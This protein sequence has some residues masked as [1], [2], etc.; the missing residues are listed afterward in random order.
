[1]SAPRRGP[2][3]RGARPGAGPAIEPCARAAARS[4]PGDIRP[5]Q[6]C[7]VA[8]G[9]R[10]AGHRARG[11]CAEPRHAGL[12]ATGLRPCPTCLRPGRRRHDR[13]RRSPSTIRPPSPTSPSTALS[14]ACRRARPQTAASPRSTS[15]AT[16]PRSPLRTRR[17]SRRCR[18]TSTRSRRCAPTATSCSSRRRRPAPATCRR[19][20]RR[21]QRKGANQISASWTIRI[22]NGILSGG[23]RVPP[24]LDGRGDRRHRLSQHQHRQLPG[25]VQQGDRGRRHHARADRRRAGVQRGRLGAERQGQG[26]SSGCALQVHKAVVS[27]RH[28][29]R[30]GQSRAYADLSAD[31]DPATGLQLLRLA[32]TRET[33]GESSGAPASRLR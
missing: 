28:R 32:A 24:R 11:G 4:P 2:A 33:T 26:A 17:G 10:R 12:S 15:P 27:D 5:R 21:P 1:M 30:T 16:P 9:V 14:T 22:S 29:A 18:S 23:I 13:D 7:V 19:R 20:W 31:A 8:P 6:A 3:T 25:G